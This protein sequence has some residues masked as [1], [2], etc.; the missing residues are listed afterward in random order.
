MV[1]EPGDPVMQYD[2]MAK[3][4]RTRMNLLEIG[5]NKDLRLRLIEIG[6]R[7]HP[8]MISRWLRGHSRPQGDRLEALLDVLKVLHRE[9]RRAARDLAYLPAEHI[10]TAA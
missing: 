6:C 7:V 8:N 10:G 3:F 4:I 2:S 9:E 1:W 5:G